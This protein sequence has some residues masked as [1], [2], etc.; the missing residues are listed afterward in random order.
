MAIKIGSRSHITSTLHN[1]MEG[2]QAHIQRITSLNTDA[3]QRAMVL[4]RLCFAEKFSY[5][6]RTTEPDKTRDAG[7]RFDVLIEECFRGIR[8]IDG[9]LTRKECLQLI[10]ETKHGGC[11]INSAVKTATAAYS[12]LTAACLKNMRKIIEHLHLPP[13]KYGLDDLDNSQAPIVRR[14]KQ[15]YKTITTSS[16]CSIRRSATPN[17]RGDG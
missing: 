15:A 13:E 16:T 2:L 7:I 4:L 6:L 12:A 3:S 5:W 17:T 10:L 8:D 9:D 14:M 1:T 11:G